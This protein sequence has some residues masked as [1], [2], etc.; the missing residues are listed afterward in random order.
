MKR[1]FGF[2]L[3]IRQRHFEGRR[4]VK[5]LAIAVPTIAVGNWLLRYEVSNFGVDPVWAYRANW[6]IITFLCFVLNRAFTWGD[7]ERH[8]SSVIKW[9]VVSLVH[10]G[11][12]QYLYPKLVHAGVHYILA[13]VIL[14]GLGPIGFMIN[15]IVTFRKEKKTPRI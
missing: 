1:T 2:L 6:P 12:S 10:T 4:V 14:L 3:K 15:N 13:S 8:K 11:V 9:V 5:A 7:R